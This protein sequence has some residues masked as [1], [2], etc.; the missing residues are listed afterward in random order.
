MN[1]P[2]GTLSKLGCIVRKADC[3]EILEELVELIDVARRVGREVPGP[4]Y[5]P[6]K[7]RISSA[8]AV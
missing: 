6:L 1:N 5:C 8:L 3:D 2:R 7:R 4:L